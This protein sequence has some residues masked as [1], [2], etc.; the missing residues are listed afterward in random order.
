MS[1]GLY[2]TGQKEPNLTRNT[3]LSTSDY[4]RIV[5]NGLSRLISVSDMVTSLASLLT[6]SLVA[7]NKYRLVTSSTIVT[8][9]DEVVAVDSTSGNLAVTLP[10]AADAWTASNSTGQSFI[11]KKFAADANNVTI[12]G[13]A[14]QTIDGDTTYVLSGVSRPF[15][16]V[17]STGSS[18]VIIG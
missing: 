13:T 14:G 10:N 2:S 11:I 6:T 12:S 9:S 4:I 8:T 5:S 17:Q 18:W 3:S 15:V 16:R 1:Y 7:V